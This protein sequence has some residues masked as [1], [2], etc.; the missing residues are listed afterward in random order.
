MKIYTYVL[1]VALG[2]TIELF[3]LDLYSKRAL[4]L[5]GLRTTM[6]WR[7]CEIVAPEGQQH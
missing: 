7:Y 2:V 1:D 3:L 5:T 4:F 6:N